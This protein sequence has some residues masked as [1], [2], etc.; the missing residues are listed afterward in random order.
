MRRADGTERIIKENLSFTASAA[1]HDRILHDVLA[2]QK[3]SRKIGS[4]LAKPNIRSI[5]MKSPITKLATA[6]IV[7]IACLIGLSLWRGTESG[8][9]LA[10]VL[11]RIEQ[12]K[13]YMYQMRSN[14]ITSQGASR[15]WLT[16]VLISQDDSMKMS[17]KMIDA[18]DTEIERHEM[19]LLPQQN[20]LV[21][22][23][24]ETKKC[25]RVKFDDAMSERYKEQYNDPH[26][27][28]KQI[29]SCDHA[30][31][32]QSVIDG[33]TVEG[34]Q[35]K[36]PAYK[37]GFMGQADFMGQP[38]KVDVKIWVDVNTFLPV[39]SEEN[40]VTKKGTCVQEVTYNFRWNIV[41]DEADFEPD[42]P[43]DYT[44]VGDFTVPAFSEETAIKA[45]RLL[46]DFAGK[47]PVN[48]S[49][50]SLKKDAKKLEGYDTTSWKELPANEKARKT[51]D[52]FM[53]ILGLH[54]F[55]E[56]LLEDKKDPAYYGETARPDDNDKV[57]LRWKLGDGQYRIIYGDLHAETVTPE[58][59]AELEK[60]VSKQKIQ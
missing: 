24:H 56:T 25:I 51:N 35:T 58:K 2:A 59:L 49:I 20:S 6:A 55:Y 32:G 29:L 36:D 31:L 39:R 13:G 43:D 10:D 4:A 12:V 50:E 15:D 33:I 5:I 37:G 1:M 44:L 23:H 11:T 18:N 8:I 26:I 30:S 53:T 9:A 40:I 48:L 34:F 16:T 45:L 7:A 46:V 27:I 47:Y 52:V 60:A 28:I 19:Y 22:I 21:T 14:L 57:L 3:E 42:I 38:E 41:V 54:L 17:L